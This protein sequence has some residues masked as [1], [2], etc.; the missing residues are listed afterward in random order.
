MTDVCQVYRADWESYLLGSL[1]ESQ[2]RAM[3]LH[4][5]GGCSVC[6][7][8]VEEARIV[9]LAIGLSVP[10]QEPSAGLE[11][12]LARSLQVQDRAMAR[13]TVRTG[14]RERGSF[15]EMQR[16]LPWG[17]LAASVL[18]AV[19]L[20]QRNMKLH[21]Q[22][23]NLTQRT[24]VPG[25]NTG[26]GSNDGD[27]A[28]TEGGREGLEAQVAQLRRQLEIF[29]QEKAAAD[30]QIAHLSAELAT[31]KDQLQAAQRDASQ[32]ETERVKKNEEQ[33]RT[34]SLELIKAKEDVKRLN[35]LTAENSQVQEL[36]DGGSL[37]ELSLKSVDTLTAASTARAIYSRGGGL[38]L[39]ASDLP[40]L[41]DNRC[42]QLWILRKSQPNV[43]SA[44]VLT[45]DNHGRGRLF[46]AGD[47][48]LDDFDGLVI[49]D[50]PEGG[51]VYS[52]GG[53]LM[54]GRP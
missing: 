34:L 40:K 31:T 9:I 26:A 12:R 53:N 5:A 54:I 17:L 23:A 15:W 24:Q 19:W 22:L 21:E 27:G 35:L 39:T 29:Q 4:L 25:Q 45:T 1:E 33:I 16:I 46:M 20:G 47:E 11:A 18:F 32:G 8:A 41:R 36:L 51:S 49:T 37:F 48:R 42:Y 13:P 7:K 14:V 28:A 50:E 30:E 38:L 6:A 10:Q 52:R 2:Q 44:G 3:E 43:V